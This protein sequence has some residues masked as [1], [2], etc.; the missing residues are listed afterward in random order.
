ML[1]LRDFLHLPQLDPLFKELLSSKSGLVVIAGLEARPAA[2]PGVADTFLPSGRST[3]FAIILQ[4]LLDAQPGLRPVV[5]ARDK[6]A[7]HVPKTMKY[8]IVQLLVEPPVTYADLISD[9]V[10][11][12]PGLLVIDR[13]TPETAPA[14]FEA[15]MSGLRVLS[16]FDTVLWGAEVTRQLAGMGVPPEL[17]PA[18]GWV[19][20]VQRVVTLCPK[21]KKPAP[22]E[23]TT[24]ARLYG[25]Y[26]SLAGI[27]TSTAGGGFVEESSGNAATFYQAD[28]CSGCGFTGR[29]GDIAVFDGY[30]PQGSIPAIFEQSSQLPYEE[31]MLRLAAR[32]HLPLEDLF[33][34]ETSQLCRTYNLLVANESALNDANTTLYRK[35]AE[36]EA[37]NRVLTQRT[38][39]LM[40][41]HDMTQALITSTSLGDLAS[42]VCRRASN[43]VGADRAILYY[44]RSSDASSGVAE[45]LAVWGWDASLLHQQLDVSQVFELGLPGDPAPYIHWPPG[46]PPPPYKLGEMRPPIPVG[47]RVPLVAQD[48]QVGLM[49]VQSTQKKSFVPGEV[50]LLKTF[51]NQAALAI[52]RAGL[53]DELRLKITQ[54][55]AAQVELVKKERLERELELAR[56]VQQSMLPCVFPD[57]PGYA[58]AACNES[59]R[60]VGG[61]FYDLIA[62]DE[63][64]F[65]VVI[66]D[67][68]DKGM[69][70]A[71]KSVLTRSL[72]LAESHRVLSPRAVLFNVNRLLLEL[73]EPS[74]FVSVFYGVVESA[75]RQ[76]T[77]TRAGHDYPL[78]F[79]QNM[80]QSLGGHG[81]VLGALDN[82][83]LE[84]NEELI[85]LA[86]GDRL[87]LYTDGLTDATNPEGQLYGLE[88]LQAL[89]QS[90]ASLPLQEM[91]LATFSSLVAYQ[92]GEDQF[93]DMTMLI[94]EVKEDQGEA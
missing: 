17:F 43:L 6:T 18:L 51:A 80:I 7:L 10:H 1:K 39:V 57:I 34:L 86:P 47:L 40:S 84:L 31:Y 53:V 50:T 72:I 61:D 37:A 15:A 94:V 89:L 74:G 44:R 88:R 79:H 46:V 92:V 83:E 19:L 41:L 82:D 58:F 36:L 71:L 38:E 91:R 5:I 75:T 25:R 12:R 23:P 49:I 64:H 81:M 65:G 67:V 85:T 68:S 24:L 56:Q 28:G 93:D 21:C 33:R 63:D 9:A 54:L 90:Y 78:L 77:Y 73:G 55:E 4:E 13:L 42:K 48:E 87:V 27:L 30:H 32:G 52:Q 59:A 69:P 26:P 35:L 29:Y 2:T 3:I 16:Q 66:G 22:P 45:V 62:L 60:Q 20:T 8:R 70:A 76:L 14:A 11:R